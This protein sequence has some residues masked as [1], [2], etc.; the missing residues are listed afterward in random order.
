MIYKE[1]IADR[2]GKEGGAMARALLQC[3]EL[4]DPDGLFP[5]HE[6]LYLSRIKILEEERIAATAILKKQIEEKEEKRQMAIKHHL[7]SIIAGNIPAVRIMGR[8]CEDVYLRDFSLTVPAK[9]AGVVIGRAGK[10]IAALSK[11]AGRRINVISDYG[12]T[13]HI[14]DV[15]I[16]WEVE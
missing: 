7:A 8:D 1:W 11:A 10:R 9:A 2:P 3:G 4:T 16:N 13:G 12:K 6:N 5:L 15:I 14:G